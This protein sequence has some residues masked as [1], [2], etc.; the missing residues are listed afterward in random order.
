MSKVTNIHGLPQSIVA[1]VTNDPYVGGGDISVTKLIDS[2]RVRVLTQL[3]HDRISVDVSERVWSLLGQA[4]HTILERAGLREEGMIVEQRLFAE[5]NGWTL[6]G[7]FDVMHLEAGKISDYKVTTV[8]KKNGSDSWTRQ[9][10]VLR[11]LAH[12]NGQEINTLEIVAIF[13]DWRK[14]E[15]QR[16]PEY[17]QAAIQVIPVPVWDLDEVDTY[18]R[19]RVMLHQMAADGAEFDCTE[20]E[21]WYSGD[22]YA[23]MKP[24]A[25]RALKLKETPF[26]PEEIPEGHDVVVRKGE[27]KRCAHYCDVAL[28]CQQWAEQSGELADAE[29]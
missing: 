28:F 20:D 25:K 8:W 12:Q 2:P 10:N 14:T 11:W 9:L 27:Y 24:G 3:N 1:A 18:V 26:T 16:N 19:E 15:A 21:R 6:S 7:Q 13:R 17:P 23:L 5:V 22:T 29:T 4:V